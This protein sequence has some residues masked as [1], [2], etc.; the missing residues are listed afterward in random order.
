MK[1]DE[2][3]RGRVE[4]GLLDL[5]GSCRDINFAEGISTSGSI[6]IMRFLMASW[7]LAQAM[8]GDGCEVVSAELSSTLRQPSGSISTVWKGGRNPE[9]IQAYFQW[10]KPD[11]V[12]CE[13][14]FFPQDFDNK[15]F[16]LQG[17]LATLG[18]LVS[19]AQSEEYYLRYEDASWCHGQY[20]KDGVILSHKVL[21]LSAD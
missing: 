2:T 5:D 10:L 14:T 17:F 19:A 4:A 20:E 12:F 16:T 9:H 7:R 13:L 8:T 3:T 21:S 6:E 1:L 15:T 11:K 18:Q